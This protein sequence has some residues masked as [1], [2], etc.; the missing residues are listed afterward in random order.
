MASKT[1]SN[2]S[3]SPRLTQSDFSELEAT[4]TLGPPPKPATVNGEAVESAPNE[5]LTVNQWVAMTTADQGLLDA[6]YNFINTT[7]E[8]VLVPPDLVRGRNKKLFFNFYGNIGKSIMPGEIGQFEVNFTYTP[9][10]R[11]ATG[12]SSTA[13]PVTPRGN[14]PFGAADGINPTINVA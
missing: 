1:T 6:I 11:L 5:I 13:A 2:V 8:G 10:T 3:Q 14:V 9:K 12:A 4:V 7:K